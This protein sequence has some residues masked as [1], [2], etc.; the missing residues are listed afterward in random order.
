MSKLIH[1]EIFDAASDELINSVTEQHLC[2]GDPADRAA[3]LTNSLANVAMSSGDFTK[4]NGD[5][6][7]RKVRAASKAS[8]TVDTTG[9][10]ATRCFIDGTRLLA[11]TDVPSPVSVTASNLITLEAVDIMELR[12]PS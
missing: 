4:S 9:S 8:V 5:V 10:G 2:S 6:S 12:D 1:D 7:G 3:V 11:K